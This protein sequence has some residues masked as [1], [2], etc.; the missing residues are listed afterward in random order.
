VALDGRPLA[1]VD[2]TADRLYTLEGSR[3]DQTGTLTLRFTPGVEAYSFT[4]G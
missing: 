2:V 4:F 1:P 3:S